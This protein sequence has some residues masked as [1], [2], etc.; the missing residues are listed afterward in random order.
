LAGAELPPADAR[1]GAPAPQASAAP[2]PEASTTPA[3]PAAAAALLPPL[4]TDVPPALAVAA[5]ALWRQ[6]EGSYLEGLAQS[7]GRAR[8]VRALALAHVAAAC[9]GFRAFLARPDGR[10]ALVAAFVARFNEVEADIRATKEA[11]VGCDD[12]GH[13]PRG[14]VACCLQA[15]RHAPLGWGLFVPDLATCVLHVHLFG[16]QVCYDAAVAW[17]ERLTP[18]VLCA[19]GGAA[20]ALRG[21]AGCAVGRV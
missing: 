8:E 15:N 6:L 18:C 17:A 21:A 10:Q 3:A 12:R 7:F 1:V 20:A 2:P 13:R 4:P 16:V 14:S 19:A 5:D 11:Q 9:R